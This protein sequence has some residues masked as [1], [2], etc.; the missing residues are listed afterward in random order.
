MSG[1]NAKASERVGTLR[2]FWLSSCPGITLQMSI[3]IFLIVAVDLFASSSAVFAPN[4]TAELKTALNSCDTSEELSEER[5]KW[6]RENGVEV[7][8]SEERK[9]KAEEAKKLARSR[10]GLDPQ[11]TSARTFKYVYI[12]AD[13]SEPL[14]LR[15]AVVHADGRGDGDQL[16]NILASHFSVGKVDDTAVRCSPYLKQ[17][18]GGADLPSPTAD[19]FEKLGGSTETFRVAAGAGSAVNDQ[20][21]FYLD[22]VGVLKKLPSNKRAASLATQCGFGEVPFFGDIFVGRVRTKDDRKWNIDFTLEDMRPDNAWVR[23]AAAE[24]MAAQQKEAHLH[25][26]GTDAEEITNLSGEG[27]GYTWQQDREQVMVT[28]TVPAGTRGKQ[29]KVKILKDAV[30]VD[31]SPSPPAD[32]SFKKIHLWLYAPVVASESMWC[33]DE[34]S[35]VLT[36]TKMKEDETWPVLSRT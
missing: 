36:L 28:V 34:G 33:L 17:L 8:T 20:V 35:I 1:R 30:T 18:S 3:A 32:S 27:D 25:G 10:A 23:A 12:P 16:P 11:S 4:S 5:L 26:P 31:L 21:N 15:S 7:E 2:E 29:C 13:G 19:T 22:E 14:E 6:L 9:K 24:N